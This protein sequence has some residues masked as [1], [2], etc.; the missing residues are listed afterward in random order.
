MKILTWN[1]NHRIQPKKISLQM[2]AALA[3]LSPDVIVLT[4]YFQGPTHD[5][6][7][8]ELRSQ[9]FSH[10]T[11]SPFKERQ[12]R[13]LIA[14]RTPLKKGEISGPEGIID[15]VP[16][17]VQHVVVEES[18]INILGLRMPLPMSAGQKKAWWDWLTTTAQEHKDLPFVITGDFNT[19]PEKS[20]GP[21]GKKRFE[22][23]RKNGW[24]YDLPASSSWWWNNKDEFGWKLDHTFLNS[25]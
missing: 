18:G 6:F 11:L 19:D 8:G 22:D 14:S 12:N 20:K 10:I 13:I 24:R 2:A 23:F 9:G 7:A 21:N 17:N 25:R 5:R 16:C 1:I 15:A 3:S 4:E